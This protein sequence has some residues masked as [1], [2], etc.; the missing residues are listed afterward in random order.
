MFCVRFIN[1]SDFVK[2][3]FQ[4][5]HFFVTIIFPDFSLLFSDFQ[6]ANFSL[7]S[8]KRIRKSFMCYI[9]F[10]QNNQIPWLLKK[11]KRFPDFSRFFPGLSKYPD[12]SQFSKFSREW[13]PCFFPCNGK[14][15]SSCEVK[16]GV[17][18]SRKEI[19]TDQK[20]QKRII[21]SIFSAPV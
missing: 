14:L 8:G 4:G 15:Y 3:L 7:Y 11:P 16:L 19:S 1:V 18:N 10:H 21:S 13:P 5:D 6:A 9:P 12:F 20:L 17:K 2:F